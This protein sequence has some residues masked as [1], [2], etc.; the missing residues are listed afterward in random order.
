MS[1]ELT[2]LTAAL[3]AENAAIFA[4]GVTTAFIGPRNRGTVAED[5]AAH[6]V[7]RDQLNADLTAAGGTA[8]LPAAGYRLPVTVDDPES[9][10]TVLLN[11]EQTCARAYR[12]LLEQA[13]TPALRRRG[14]DGLTACARRA[15]HWR[16]ALRQS[17]VTVAFPGGGER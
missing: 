1:D 3:D 16:G 15:A 4:Y 5:V 8:A 17:P 9:A 11:A 6:R 12:A 2:A 13:G 7:A 10:A 14:V